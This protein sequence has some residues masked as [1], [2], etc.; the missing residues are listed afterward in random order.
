MGKKQALPSQ[1]ENNNT[2]TAESIQILDGREAVRRRPAMYIGNT[3]SLGLHHLVFEV[4]DNSIDEALIGCCN[5]IEVFIHFDNSVTIVDNGRGIPV[6]NHPI[7][8]D[9]STVEV[10][11]TKLHAGGKFSNKVY[12]FS[13]GLH[14]VG[15]SVVNFLSE[16]CEVEVRRDGR[17]YYQRYERGIAKTPLEEIGKSKHT[18]TRIRFRPDP[19]IF[20][21]IKFSYEILAN[22]FKELAFLNAGLSITLVDERTNKE[23]R[24]LYKGGINEFVKSLNE[25]KNVL[26]PKPIYLHGSREVV[27][28]EAT[29]KK[30]EVVVEVSIQYN[31]SYSEILYTFAN[32][33]NNRDG[34]TH[35]LGFR[36]ALTR[37]LNDYAKRNDLLKKVPEG[38]TGEDVREG[39]T[40]VV[41]V[42]VSEPQFEGQTKSKLLNP[43][44]AGIVEQIVNEGLSEYLE[45]NPTIARRILDKVITAAQARHAA[46]RAREIVR[47]SAIEVGTLPSKLADC[48]EKDR[49]LTELY[50]V[51]GDSAGGSAKLARD[52]HFQAV[53][54]LRGKIINVEKARL[55]KVLSNEEIRTLV[56]ALGTGIGEENFDI[57]K[58]RYD[59]IILMTDADV[60]GAHIRTLLL[61][62]FYRQ[63]RPLIEESRIY[64]AQPP[65]YKVKKGK[66]ERYLE[67]EEDKDRFLLEQGFR[68]ASVYVVGKR[69]GERKL[70]ATES[71]HLMEHLLSL[72]QFRKSIERKGIPFPEYLSQRDKKGRFPRFVVVEGIKRH[73]AYEEK[74]LARFFEAENSEPDESNG[75][76][77]MFTSGDE[78]SPRRVNS[79]NLIEVPES[80][81]I[82]ELWQNLESLG[83]NPGLF[84]DEKEES[85][86][87]DKKPFR[88]VDSKGEQFASSLKELMEIIMEIGSRGVTIQRYKGLGEM[89]PEQLWETTMNPKTRTILQVTLEDAIEAERIC[90]ILMGDQVEPR[91]KFIQDHAPKVRNLDI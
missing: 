60:D 37:T 29:G 5:K 57:S 86:Q 66:V 17:V 19:E 65:L 55:D 85:T 62:F 74:D 12:R 28:D 52:R 7:E 72:E 41:S 49:S 40:A 31:D 81:S 68:E 39:L 1:G 35:A 90:S 9:K 91:R 87:K 56:T 54:P 6:E 34:G 2:Y 71:R 75:V 48:A 18:G 43:E 51:E 46:R 36:K 21:D 23:A 58:L 77:D 4:V 44:V 84:V 3:D 20:G 50:I 25:G 89:N 70:T 59:K 16:W 42:K 38:I 8:K 27:K 61:T 11:M 24:F 53:L 83:I 82:E 22:R 32:T 30:E 45:E 13:G 88:I 15:V 26:N 14:G 10:V 79:H 33:I 67:K 80:K 47:K 73:F 78:A 69:Q 76:P 64:I 63:M